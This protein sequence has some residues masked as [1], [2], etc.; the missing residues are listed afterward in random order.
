MFDNFQGDTSTEEWRYSIT[1]LGF[2]TAPDR[3]GTQH[4]IG[5]LSLYIPRDNPYQ[6]L[7]RL[8][9]FYQPEGW[10]LCRSCFN[11]GSLWDVSWYVAQS[12]QIGLLPG[13]SAVFGFTINNSAAPRPPGAGT[14]PNTVLTATMNG[15]LGFWEEGK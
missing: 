7:Y 10:F 4:G 11:F 13:E 12:P 1:N 14:G 2:L 9:N 6:V 5:D 8:A 15:A 3:G